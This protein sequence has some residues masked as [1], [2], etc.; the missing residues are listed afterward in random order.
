MEDRLTEIVPSRGRKGDLIPILQRIQAEFGY[1]P[2]EAIVKV[3]ESTG[4]AE[5]R[6]FGVA[7]FYAQFRFTPMGRN[8]VMVCRGTA[9]HVKGAPR[10][11][12]E[13]EKV[14][15]IKEGETTKDLEYTLESVACIGCCG[16][17]PCIMVNKEV[18]GR[19]TTKEISDIF[20]TRGEC[21]AG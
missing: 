12:E 11:L 5:S 9:C 6:V 20:T 13:I 19:L 16:L 4:V 1:L 18:H 7:S 3:A 10:I 14:L 8:R 21:D 15:K 17:A 2:E